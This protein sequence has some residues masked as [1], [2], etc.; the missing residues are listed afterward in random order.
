MA[1]STLSLGL[2]DLRSEVGHFL[3][4]GRGVAAGE[5]AWTTP[6]LNGINAVIKSGVR[7]FMSPPPLGPGQPSHDW[8]FLK[9]TA[10]LA[11]AAD[12]EAVPLPDDFGGIEG[13]LSVSNADGT[14]GLWPVQLAGEGVLRQNHSANGDSRGRPTMAAVRPLKGTT[15]TTG[16]R[17]DLYLW[18]KADGAYTIGLTYYVLVDAQTDLLPY[19]L[20]GGTHAETLLESCLAVAEERLDDAMAVHKAKFMER[21]A[22]SVSLD[23]RMMPAILGYNGDNSDAL[24]WS[25]RD[26]HGRSR[27]TYR[28]IQH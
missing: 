24:G 28:G 13:D 25:R 23:R 2:A 16:Q 15:E 5:T 9:P 12:D 20:G 11:V 8:T 4:Y 19:A 7:Q 6:Q 14:Y 27:V 22:A 17:H 1:E 10:S 21:L 18:P 3:G 26:E